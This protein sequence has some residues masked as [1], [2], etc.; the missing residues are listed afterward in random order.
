MAM[1]GSATVDAN[2]PQ[3]AE[4]RMI[5]LGKYLLTRGPF[6]CGPVIRLS[7]LMWWGKS[8]AVGTL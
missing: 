7:V 3:R 2:T 5:R 6:L 4:F 8:D 1:K